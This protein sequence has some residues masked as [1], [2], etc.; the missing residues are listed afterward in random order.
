MVWNEC[1][2]TYSATGPYNNVVMGGSPASSMY[3][4]NLSQA[5]SAG[6]GNGVQ[7]TYDAKS[8][9]VKIE[10]NLIGYGCNSSMQYLPNQHYV[11]GNFTYDWF[12]DFYYSTDGG[13]NYTLVK[14]ELIAR[15]ASNQGLAYT[16]NW[17]LSNVNYSTIIPLPPNFTHVK[18]E[19]RGDEPAQRHQNVYTRQVVISNYKPWAI[20]KSGTWTSL[21]KSSGHFRVRHG[22]DWVD[23]SNELLSDIGKD[24]KGHNRIRKSGIWKQQNKLGS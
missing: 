22:N 13:K 15:H 18:I 7:F 19:V 6:Y 24:N 11:Q 12:G 2:G 3:G 16:T 14:Q 21:N 4:L 1:W 10:I 23:R 20:R 8:N 5:K 9:S 17:H